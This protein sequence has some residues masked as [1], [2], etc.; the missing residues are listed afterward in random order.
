MGKKQID[1]NSLDT[2]VCPVCLLDNNI[3]LLLPWNEDL[4][5]L[6]FVCPECCNSMIDSGN[7]FTEIYIQKKKEYN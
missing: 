2:F 4:D 5:S 7:I 3:G 6:A 1:L